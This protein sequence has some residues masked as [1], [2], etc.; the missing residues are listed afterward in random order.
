MTDTSYSEH[1]EN[2]E[3]NENTENTEQEEQNTD[4]SSNTK[5]NMAKTGSL[6]M[7]ILIILWVLLGIIAFIK[8][9]LCFGS[10]SSALEKIL[11]LVLAILFGPLYFLYFYISPKYCKSQSGGR[12]KSRN[13]ANRRKK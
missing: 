6:F 4:T 12:S 5:I 11:G 1:T 9:I 10:S 2:T 3:N 13:R 7:M 8:S